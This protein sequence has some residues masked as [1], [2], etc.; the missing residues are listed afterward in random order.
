ML[1]R[2]FSC[3]PPPPMKAARALW[4]WRKALGEAWG[5]DPKSSGM[6]QARKQARKSLRRP[7]GVRGLPPP[8]VAVRRCV[9]VMWS[10]G[11]VCGSR[12]DRGGC[13]DMVQPV[14]TNI[15]NGG[16]CRARISWI[17]APC[18]SRGVEQRRPVK[19]VP[20]NKLGLVRWRLLDQGR[21]SGTRGIIRRL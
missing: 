12:G 19:K 20:W 2:A 7:E 21:A 6:A 3:R 13:H 5:D 10:A 17:E 9:A 18:P 16:V 4:A 1:E 8:G 15:R 14:R 11:P